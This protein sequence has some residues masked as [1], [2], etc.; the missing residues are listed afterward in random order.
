VF[1]GASANLRTLFESADSDDCG[2]GFR[3]NAAAHSDESGRGV[4]TGMVSSIRAGG[5]MQITGSDASTVKALAKAR[6]AV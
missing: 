5:R 6:P 2:Q 3:L 1:D 4:V